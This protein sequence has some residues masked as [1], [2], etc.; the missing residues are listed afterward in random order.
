MRG[1]IFSLCVPIKC[2]RNPLYDGI[3][4][5]RPLTP[6]RKHNH[7]PSMFSAPKAMSA[8][9]FLLSI[10]F[11]GA[12]V[13]GGVTV[14][15]VI[16]TVAAGAC[17]TVLVVDPPAFVIFSLIFCLFFTKCGYFFSTSWMILVCLSSISGSVLA[18]A[19]DSV[20]KLSSTYS[21]SSSNSSATICFRWRWASVYSFTS[22]MLGFFSGGDAYDRPDAGRLT[23]PESRNFNH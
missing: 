21:A 16:T 9:I 8:C 13:A 22:W 4:I 11:V 2:R 14:G 5:G 18:S 12:V 19:L 10:R 6:Q 15:L 17:L 23:G 20:I 7:G 3:L 1:S